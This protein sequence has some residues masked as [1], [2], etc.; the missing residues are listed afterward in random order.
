M[1]PLGNGPAERATQIEIAST[2]L[3]NVF[4]ML[5]EGGTAEF[6]VRRIGRLTLRAVRARDRVPEPRQAGDMAID[7]RERAATAAVAGEAA[8]VID[9]PRPAVHRDETSGRGTRRAWLDHVDRAETRNP[10]TYR[11]YR[12]EYGHRQAAESDRGHDPAELGS[13]TR[14]PGTH[15]NNSRLNQAETI[16]APGFHGRLNEATGDEGMSSTPLQPTHG[17]ASRNTRLGQTPPYIYPPVPASSAVRPVRSFTTSA[18][19]TGPVADSLAA[20]ETYRNYWSSEGNR[21]G[22]REERRGPR[23]PDR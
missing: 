20:F 6:D 5:P 9:R 14:G 1:V 22:R 15:L 18:T 11:P 21:Q 13:N 10:A 23:P 2:A 19:L 7:G 4:A 12:P 17:P 8:R 3:G 16:S